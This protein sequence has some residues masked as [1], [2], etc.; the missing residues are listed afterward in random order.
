MHF[1]FKYEKIFLFL[2][3]LDSKNSK[4]K[5]FLCGCVFSSLSLI[6]RAE[7]NVYIT[8]LVDNAEAW[9]VGTSVFEVTL[10]GAVDEDS[11]GQDLIQQR[12]LTQTND[13]T[14]TKVTR[15][16]AGINRKFAA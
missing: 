8:V 15:N 9:E 3:V 2:R 13:A 1:I 7:L 16:Q 6:T 4:D 14:A 5:L 11:R 10:A 12:T